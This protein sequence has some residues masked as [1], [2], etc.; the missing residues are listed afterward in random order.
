LLSVAHAVLGLI[1]YLVP[2]WYKNTKKLSRSSAQGVQ[3]P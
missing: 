2:Y 3:R 1:I